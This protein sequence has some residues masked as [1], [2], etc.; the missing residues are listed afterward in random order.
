MTHS[1]II[2]FQIGK[3]GFT[4]GTTELLKKT[5]KNHDLIKIS[6]LKSCTRDRQ[7]IKT[8]SEKICAELQKSEGREFGCK[9]IGFTLNIRKLKKI[10]K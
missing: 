4:Q 6:V 3:Q 8:L 5:F 10:K 2:T 9:I 1:E 7:E